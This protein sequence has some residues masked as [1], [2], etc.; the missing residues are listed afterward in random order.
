[1]QYDRRNWKLGYQTEEPYPV[2]CLEGDTDYIVIVPVENE[3]RLL[4][5]LHE[6]LVIDLYRSSREFRIE[7]EEKT[8]RW[9]E[10]GYWF[11]CDDCSNSSEKERWITFEKQ[12][13]N[14]SVVGAARIDG[15]KDDQEGELLQEKTDELIKILSSVSYSKEDKVRG[16]SKRNDLLDVHKMI[17]YAERIGW[18]GE[19][20]D[21]I[22]KTKD[23]VPN[24]AA[25]KQIAEAFIDEQQSGWKENDY[26][27]TDAFFIEP[28]YKWIVCYSMRTP[29]GH[30]MLD[31]SYK[32]VR[33]RR[34]NGEVMYYYSEG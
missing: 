13:E 15:S 8:D 10:E 34:D 12:L 17:L 24:E 16:I 21:E 19:S 14:I 5:R 1:M 30:M 9:E 4:E 11:Y 23:S 27:E 29:E 2:F 28:I 20:T 31:G 7:A 18:I 25:A 32:T 26:Y 22:D 3:E 6:D 33:I